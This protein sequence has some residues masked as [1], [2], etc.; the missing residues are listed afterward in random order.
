M[1]YIVLQCTP[2]TVFYTLYNVYC[3]WNTPTL[4]INAIKRGIPL[5]IP[6]CVSI[7]I[8]MVGF[9]ENYLCI[10]VIVSYVTTFFILASHLLEW[11]S[12]NSL[13]D[14]KVLEVKCL[15]KVIRKGQVLFTYSPIIT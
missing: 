10:C 3:I 2:I 1:S 7:D 6:G 12:R 11:Y 5:R 15:P 8:C 4:Y 13:F 9:I 14:D